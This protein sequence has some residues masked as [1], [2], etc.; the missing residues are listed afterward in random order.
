MFAHKP[1]SDDINDGILGICWP[2]VLS[3]LLAHGPSTMV[4]ALLLGIEAVLVEF[5]DLP[6]TWQ[7]F[8]TNHVAD[9][10]DELG[11]VRK[12]PQTSGS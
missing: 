6:E 9:M 12:T 11:L 8:G 5:P 7:L 4:D 3:I 10:L 1:N 2:S